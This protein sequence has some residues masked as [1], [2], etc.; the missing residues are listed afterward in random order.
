MT[1]THKIFKR[2]TD[3]GMPEAQAEIVVNELFELRR[4]AEAASTRAS[5]PEQPTR[6][7]SNPFWNWYIGNSSRHPFL[8]GLGTGLALAALEWAIV[9]PVID[10][11]VVYFRGH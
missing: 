9:F 1:D 8:N 2:L 11:L 4:A 6:Y 5:V 7:S 10:C 3:A